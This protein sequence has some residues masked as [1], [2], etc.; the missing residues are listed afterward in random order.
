MQNIDTS[1]SSIFKHTQFFDLP[2]DCHYR[3]YW[4]EIQNTAI[5]SGAGS[6]IGP[7]DRDTWH[8]Y[9]TVIADTGAPPFMMEPYNSDWQEYVDSGL[10]AGFNITTT[11]ASSVCNLKEEAPSLY[12]PEFGE[13]TF[14]PFDTG[15]FD[16]QLQEIYQ[17]SCQS[18]VHNYLY[19][20]IDR[21]EFLALYQPVK[22]LMAKL[23]ELTEL[24]YRDGQLV[25]LCLVLLD[26]M[27]QSGKGAILK[28]LMRKN[29]PALKGLGLTLVSRA[30]ERSKK[31][32][33]EQLILALYKE[34]GMSA[35][36]AN[37][38]NASVIRR[39]GLL[40]KTI[41]QGESI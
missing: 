25:G 30:I 5:K 7:I 27:D 33:F 19:S 6:V 24:V 15:R 39:Y 4:Q 18:F 41:C 29:D 17:L 40:A 10:K 21:S 26:G 23:P 37:L 38:V 36:I 22:P 1:S 28:T 16:Q 34:D 31:L 35:Y 2:P 32:G 9:R 11:Y 14:K 8:R 12:Y 20:A 3:T 13:L